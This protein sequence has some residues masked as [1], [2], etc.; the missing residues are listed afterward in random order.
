MLRPADVPAGAHVQWEIEL[1]GFEMPK[2]QLF[3]FSDLW[4]GYFCSSFVLLCSHFS[5]SWS[6]YLLCVSFHFINKKVSFFVKR[7]ERP[8]AQIS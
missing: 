4:F 1:L 2:V 8:K 7:K 5:P 6:L 3:S